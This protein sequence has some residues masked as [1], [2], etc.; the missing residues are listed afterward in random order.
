MNL[1]IYIFMNLDIYIYV[2]LDVLSFFN[3]H[4]VAS[5]CHNFHVSFISTHLPVDEAPH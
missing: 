2:N 4:R 1:D 5:Q 3:K